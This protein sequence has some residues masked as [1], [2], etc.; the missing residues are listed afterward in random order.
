M[1]MGRHYLFLLEKTILSSEPRNEV[2]KETSSGMDMGDLC[3]HL[4][5]HGL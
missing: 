4:V 1:T 2:L 3:I 5:D